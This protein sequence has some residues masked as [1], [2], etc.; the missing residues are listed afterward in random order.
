[1][2]CTKC[3][4]QLAEGDLRCPYCGRP[5]QEALAGKPVGS[6]GELANSEIM[7]HAKEA[8]SGR[9]VPTSITWGDQDRLPHV[10]GA[11]ILESIIPNAQTAIMENTGH[12]PYLEKPKETAQLCL[13]FHGLG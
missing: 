10:S 13:K 5:V 4:G 9:S 7:T 2:F 8:L 11:E 12:V 6:G 3:G 1:M